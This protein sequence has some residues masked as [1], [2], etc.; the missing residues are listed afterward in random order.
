MLDVKVGKQANRHY[1]ENDAKVTGD[2]E[3]YVVVLIASPQKI[4]PDEGKDQEEAL[5]IIDK[6][7]K[8]RALVALFRIDRFYWFCHKV[9]SSFKLL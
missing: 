1:S 2:N 8:A 3:G 9:F 6:V 7:E 4:S 5:D